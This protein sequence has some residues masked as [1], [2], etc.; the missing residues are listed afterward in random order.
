MRIEYRM[1]V[2][3]TS[4]DVP[5]PTEESTFPPS[6]TEKVPPKEATIGRS[7]YWSESG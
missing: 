2:L 5:E 4:M 6:G 7:I 1:C 3:L